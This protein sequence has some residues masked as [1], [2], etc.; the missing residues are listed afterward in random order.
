MASWYEIPAG[1]RRKLL[2]FTRKPKS[3]RIE[4]LD[5]R[6]PLVKAK[7]QIEALATILRD[8]L[9]WENWDEISWEDA[10]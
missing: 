1:R 10:R 6:N 5:L 7:Q 9:Y 3:T 2:K 4:Q 8:S